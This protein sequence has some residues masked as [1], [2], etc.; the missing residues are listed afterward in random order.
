M[1]K[2]NELDVMVQHEQKLLAAALIQYLCIDASM[3][4]EH[5]STAEASEL[6]YEWLRGEAMD[7]CT[8]T[9]DWVGEA[10]SRRLECASLI[11]QRDNARKA[12]G[13]AHKRADLAESN[14]KNMC[15][16]FT[17]QGEE[18]IELR[19]KVDTLQ[20]RLVIKNSM[21]ELVEARLNK[22]VAA[23]QKAKREEGNL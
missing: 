9:H 16:N 20:G 3:G 5:L 10:L 14:H 13:N 4:V 2:F 12:A 11:D 7:Q 8:H 21:L 6:V 19:D 18:V 17:T 23:E 1:G 15:H 22:Y